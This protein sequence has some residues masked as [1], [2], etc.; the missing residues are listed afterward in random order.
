MRHDDTSTRTA[1]RQ[2]DERPRNR[3]RRSA[4]DKRPGFVRRHPVLLSAL[5]LV[6]VLVAGV[7]VFALYLNTQ[8]GKID[9]FELG[10][11][12]DDRRP[13][14]VEGDAVNILL[15]GLDE[16]DGRS[17]AEIQDGGWDS[18]VVRSDA[19]MVLHLTADRQ[20]AYVISIPR[21]SYVRLY[22]EDGRPQEM[23]RIN[24]AFSLYGPT[25]FRSTV[26]NVTEL[27][28]NHVAIADFAGFE[29]ITNALGGVA[30]TTPGEGTQQLDGEESLRYVRTRSGLPSEDFDRIARQQNFLR[31][32]LGKTLSTGTLTNPFT[33]TSTLKAVVGNLTVDQEFDTG[34]IRSL[35]LSLRGLR[36][37]DVTFV[38]APFG[39]YGTTDAGASIVR[40]DE[41]QSDELW[42]ATANDRMA[43]Y[44]EEYGVE[45]EQ[46]PQ[47]GDVN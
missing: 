40:L 21:D 17:I 37:S 23:N 5:V 30:V 38:T 14:Q 3:P 1:D 16:G 10:K 20:R 9:R 43:E 25:A 28:M 15:A 44:L 27:R 6:G 41:K 39:S 2:P 19:I 36:V 46:L 12:P 4:S 24:A 18:G 11:I 13:T 35:A 34:K 33:L 29:D 22:G 42:E 31:A 7:L 8:L 47:P 26:E 32:M 45:S